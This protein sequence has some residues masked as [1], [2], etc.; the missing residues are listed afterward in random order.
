MYRTVQVSVLCKELMHLFI[1]EELTRLNPADGGISRS[2]I[3][4]SSMQMWQMAQLRSAM[5]RSF[6]RMDR[7]SQNLCLCGKRSIGNRCACIPVRLSSSGSA[8]VV[9]VLSAETIMVS[10]FGNSHA[11]L[12]RAGKAIS[13]SHVP[14]VCTCVIRNNPSFR[15][16][17]VVL[18][19]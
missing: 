10:N 5:K 12:C 4:F 1:A 11:V 3:S 9:A 8:A 16:S 2:S 15:K 6:E 13:L 19:N 17:D 7:V 18:Y 14:K